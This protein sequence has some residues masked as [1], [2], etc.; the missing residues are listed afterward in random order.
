MFKKKQKRN[1]KKIY[2]KLNNK[3]K[4]IINAYLN[5]KNNFFIKNVISYTYNIYFKIF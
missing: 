1:R 3:I 4:K 5:Y 2:I